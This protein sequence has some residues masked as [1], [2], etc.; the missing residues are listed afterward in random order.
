MECTMKSSGTL[1]LAIA[2]TLPLSALAGEAAKHEHGAA[3]HAGLELNA[4][5]KWP[6][7]EPLRQAMT[8]I[9]TSVA[10]ALPA[11]HEGKL[12]PVQYDALGN[13]V[14]AQ[15]TYIVQN[16][17][18]DPKADAQ[19]HNIVGDIMNGIETATGRQHGEERALGVVKMAQALN[20]YGKYFDHHGWQAIKAGH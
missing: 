3:A 9:R 13:D 5:K 18:L 7:D 8:K 6:T 15:I 14:T 11:A 10:T 12:T 2:L 4:G 1:L 19:L 17:K 16:C 20:N